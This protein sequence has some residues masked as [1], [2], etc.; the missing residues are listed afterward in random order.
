MLLQFIIQNPSL[1]LFLTAVLLPRPK[2]HAR[3]ALLPALSTC[4]AARYTQFAALC[5]VL[6]FVLRTLARVGGH[7]V[8]A[9]YCTGFF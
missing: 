8:R 6:R 9:N 5:F 3:R 7:G 2:G 1:F 4:V